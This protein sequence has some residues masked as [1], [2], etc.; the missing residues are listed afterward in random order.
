MA[1]LR[2]RAGM[3]FAVRNV[4]DKKLRGPIPVAAEVTDLSAA[5]RSEEC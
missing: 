5:S 4:P 3:P 2:V 1:P